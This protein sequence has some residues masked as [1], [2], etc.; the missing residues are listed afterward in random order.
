MKMSPPRKQRNDGA[1][2]GAT[3]VVVGCLIFLVWFTVRVLVLVLFTLE[4]VAL[5]VLVWL[6][7]IGPR[8]RRTLFV[9]SDS[10]IWKEYLE[11]TII[12]RLPSH[13]VVLNWSRR[14]QWGRLKLSSFLFRRF[15]G[16]YEFN[17]IAVVFERFRLAKAYRFWQPFRDLKHGNPE[18]LR[19]LEEEFWRHL[20]G[21]RS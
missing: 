13:S 11:R 9:Y 21:G 4:T 8:Q 1:F 14:R 19:N 16:N 18:A 2:A 6:W 3:W 12:P 17:P 7:W 10:P 20:A 15:A 5:Y